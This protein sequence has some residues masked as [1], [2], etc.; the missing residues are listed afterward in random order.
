MTPDLHPSYGSLARSQF[1]DSF[2]GAHAGPASGRG[3][4]RKHTEREAAFISKLP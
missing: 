1:L 3:S 4:A 2:F